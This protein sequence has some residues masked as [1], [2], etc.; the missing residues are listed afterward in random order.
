MKQ[1][2]LSPTGKNPAEKSLVKS[3]YIS[4]G[5]STDRDEPLLKLSEDEVEKEKDNISGR[6]NKKILV[7]MEFMEV[8]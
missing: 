2:A 7:V 8:S 5:Y 4:F 6:R 1:R 3:K